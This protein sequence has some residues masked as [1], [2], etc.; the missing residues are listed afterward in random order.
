MR[1]DHSIDTSLNF[2]KDLIDLE[3]NL[4]RDEG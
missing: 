1:N 2:A 3:F 4:A